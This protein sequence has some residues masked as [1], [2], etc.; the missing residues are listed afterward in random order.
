MTLLLLRSKGAPGDAVRSVCAT[1][2]R[3]SER[4]EAALSTDGPLGTRAG[5]LVHE[6]LASASPRRSECTISEVMPLAG[7][8]EHWYASGLRSLCDWEEIP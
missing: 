7:M 8:R 6:R 5:C 2:S 4:L 1:A 3:R